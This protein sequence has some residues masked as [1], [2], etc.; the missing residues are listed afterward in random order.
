LKSAIGKLRGYVDQITSLHAEFVK[1]CLKGRFYSVARNFIDQPIYSISKLYLV[2]VAD[3]LC[4]F[5]YG[6][7]VYIGLNELTNAVSFLKIVMTTPSIS[8]SQV[9]V[10]SYK[11]FLL[12]SVITHNYPPPVLKD[13]SPVMTKL[14]SLVPG[15]ISFIN[16]LLKGNGSDVQGFMAVLAEDGNR[17]LALRCISVARQMNVVQLSRTFRALPISRIKQFYPFDD[18]VAGDEDDRICQF[19]FRLSSQG[20]LSIKIGQMEGTVTF[21]DESEAGL[22]SMPR[23]ELS[24]GRFLEKQIQSIITLSDKLRQAD[25]SIRCGERQ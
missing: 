21:D 23:D 4:Y 6:A 5:Y 9:Q 7:M 25:R 19:L 17:G 16:D 1:V 12:L 18:I 10:D 8:I 24:V 22:S 2:D 15:Y 20:R 3:Y 11:K 14:P 13:V